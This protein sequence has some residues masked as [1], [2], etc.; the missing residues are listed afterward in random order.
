MNLDAKVLK[1]LDDLIHNGE[2]VLATKRTPSPYVIGD[3]QVDSQLAYQWATSAQNLLATV[4]GRDSEHYKNL[5]A[6][7]GKNLTYSPVYHA[8][9]ILRAAKEDY[10]NGHLFEL[11]KIVEAELFDDFLD[12]AEHL[13]QKDYYQAAAVVAGAVLEDALRK[14]CIQHEITLGSKPKLD[15][16][17]A[18]L[19]KKGTY[20][21]LVQKRITTLADLRNKAA[22]G[23]WDKFDIEDVKEML[24]SVR[25]F[26]EEHFA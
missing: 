11:R 14:L 26:M 12:Q 1:R 4:F 23:E 24:P 25:R 3:S 19:A 7:V 13:L 9:G 2:Q 10:E 17:N 22:H 21:K 6:Q 15:T 5:I 20:S 16:M 18:D 8:Q